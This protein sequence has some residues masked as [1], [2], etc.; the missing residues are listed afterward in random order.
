M[1]F[2]IKKLKPGDTLLSAKIVSLMGRCCIPQLSSYFIYR[3]PE[4]LQYFT[5]LIH[6][7]TEAVFY[8]EEP[9]TAEILGAVHFKIRGGSIWLNT[10]CIHAKYR[11]QDIG[12]SLLTEA[13]KTLTENSDAQMFELDVFETNKEN[14]SLYLRLGMEISEYRYWYDITSYCAEETIGTIGVYPQDQPL[15]VIADSNG[16]KQL[17]AAEKHLG[18]LINNTHLV[19][20]KEI[21]HTLLKKLNQ[22][23]RQFLLQSVCLVSERERELLL[24]DRSFHLTVPV[25]KLLRKIG[26]H[27]KVK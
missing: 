19:V 1:H 11:S 5:K 6:S 22:A 24:L 14:F 7:S 23:F 3:E 8:A 13:L 25:N 17:Y 21:D 12:F 2:F 20:R 4:Y 18:T 9:D 16:F 15:K 27:Q 10:I 26:V